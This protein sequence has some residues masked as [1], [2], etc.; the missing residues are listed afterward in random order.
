MALSPA[1]TCVSCP[2]HSG[3]V[4][5]PGGAA[6]G[7]PGGLFGPAR[8]AFEGMLSGLADPAAVSWT[9]AELEQRLAADSR[10]I[11]RRTL[12]GHL[13]WREA[14]ERRRPGGVSGADQ[15]TR[16]RVECGH[17]RPLASVVGAVTVTRRA[18]RAP[19]HP[20]LYPAGAELS[21]PPGKY[22]HGVQR[23]AAGEALGDSFGQAA[24]AA[25]RSTGLAIG[26][27]Q[28]EELTQRAAADFGSFYATTRPPAGTAAAGDVLVLS[29][30]ASGITMRPDGL[31]PKT[32]KAAAKSRA[33]LATRL[34]RGE[35]RH[36]KRMAEIG[37][38]YDITP[39]P[40][41][42]ADILTQPGDGPHTKTPGP[43]AHGT[44]LTASITASAAQVIAAAF[45]EAERRDPHHTRR[46]IA[47]VDGNRD[48]IHRITAEA[49]R[50]GLE[51]PILIDFI[52][53]LQH[54]WT[55]A[56]CFH[57]EADPAA[58][59]WIAA[60]TRAILGGHTAGVAA[61]IRNTPALT[62]AKRKT[63][64]AAARYLEN[65]QPYLGYPRALAAGWPIATGV[66]EGAARHLVKDRMCI[67]GARWGLPGAEA[68][69]Q[70]RAL[71]A[72]GDFDRYWAYHLAQEHRRNHQNRYLNGEVPRAA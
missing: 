18:Y 26:K 44:W 57:R 47:L 4:A 14:T 53:V 63:A 35:V 1:C 22:S 68:I 46:W 6:A 42:P 7:G 31:R 12:Q 69:L 49:R 13:D 36:R 58:E 59:T 16:T 48:Q 30:D 8:E 32:R 9:H 54:L 21:L 61:A 3:V 29:A 25:R 19:G 34:T 56:W 43:T 66:I 15:V 67:G 64:D 17:R 10:E 27:R 11:A 33:K 72:N 41:T 5:A 20:N 2:L 55:A 62:P 71:T 24:G 38:V 50:R 40:R 23:L 51:L 45:R 37:A 65:N 28:V 52:H 70:L 39:A 60:H